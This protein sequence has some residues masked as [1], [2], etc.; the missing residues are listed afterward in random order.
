MN[1]PIDAVSSLRLLEHV[2]QRDH[3]V[4]RSN[5]DLQALSD[6]FDRLMAHEPGAM[7]HNEPS[8]N[9]HETMATEVVGKGEAV[10]RQTFQQI[11]Q[12][13]ADVPHLDIRE[14]SAR[15]IELTMQVA[16]TQFHFNACTHVAQS[17]K[18]GMQTLMKNQ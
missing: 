13:Q 7:L 12:F 11:Q 9:R 6:R 2:A 4:A 1:L 18:S 8:N 16:V 5:G 17:G 14:L 15:H 10:M 3:G